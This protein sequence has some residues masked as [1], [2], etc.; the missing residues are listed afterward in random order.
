MYPCRYTSVATMSKLRDSIIRINRNLRS[1]CFS[2]YNL[3]A[4]FY[5]Q[6]MAAINESNA[7][8]IDNL[9]YENLW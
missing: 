3:V 5:E 2:S 4:G 6:L 1:H 9:S 7:V 8:D